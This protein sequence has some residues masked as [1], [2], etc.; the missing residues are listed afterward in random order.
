[1]TDADDGDG[2][3]DPFKCP[4]CGQRDVKC[5]GNGRKDC[6]SCPWEFRPSRDTTAETTKQVGLHNY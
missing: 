6:T 3:D 5:S 4:K 1:M 2:E